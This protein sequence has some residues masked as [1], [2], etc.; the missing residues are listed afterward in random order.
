M[1]SFIDDNF[2]LAE[3]FLK[4]DYTEIGNN[5]RKEKENL[6]IYEEID[7]LLVGC[8]VTKN[9]PLSNLYKGEFYVVRF[10][11]ANVD[12]MHN[13]KQ[14]NCIIELLKKL[15]ERMEKNKGYY[16]F[17]IP[18]HI[19]DIIKAYNVVFQ[20]GIFCGG[21]VEE[22]ISGKSVS[23]QLKDGLK[24]FFGNSS[25]IEKH[26]NTLMDMTYKSF[27]SYQGQYH[28]SYVTEEKAGKIYENWIE[29]SLNEC[30]DKNVIIAEYEGS[31]IGFVTIAEKE[32]AVE[33]VLSAVENKH[34]KLG[35]YR[36]MI[37]YI[38]NY[39]NENGKSF[40]TS[41][42]FDNFIVQGVWNSIGLKPFYSI[43]NFHIL[44]E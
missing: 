9:I 29:S 34:R 23:N 42:Q 28:L 8:M 1:V 18:S 33:G 20:G 38:V 25:Y 4:R 13:E 16:N 35:A 11:C 44:S 32:H 12:T 40:I 26:K 41:T 30:N 6:T 24:V 36:A 22:I 3:G 15:K 7:D 2:T 39:A 10:L 21:T 37:S 17:R 14:M 27:E 5:I 31:P 19:V 43:Y